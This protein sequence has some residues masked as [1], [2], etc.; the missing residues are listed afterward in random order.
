MVGGSF[1]GEVNRD[2]VLFFFYD[3]YS[4][5]SRGNTYHPKPKRRGNKENYCFQQTYN[6]KK[7]KKVFLIYKDFQKG[8]G[9][10]SY[11]TNG[12]LIYG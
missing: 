1:Q 7:E 9:A 8:S 4:H 6:V 11:M 5:I 12:L 10:K 3:I 2:H